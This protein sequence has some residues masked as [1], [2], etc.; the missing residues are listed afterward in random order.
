[1]KTS[2]K[3]SSLSAFVFPG[4]GL[5]IVNFKWIGFSI[6]GMTLCYLYFLLTILVD[7]SN[8]VS[9]L[10]V[11]GELPLESAKMLEV[12][13]KLRSEHG[14]EYLDL[15]SYLIFLIWIYSILHSYFL[16]KKID[17]GKLSKD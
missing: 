8:E 14:G 1:M 17:E 12:I 4:A 13:S 3:A 10:I 15:T 11:N 16:G 2:L 9:I 5:L 6:I 7:I